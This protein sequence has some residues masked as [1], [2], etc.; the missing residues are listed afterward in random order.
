MSLYVYISEKEEFK[1]FQNPA[2]LFWLKENLIFGDWTSG[3][4][5]DGSYSHTKN[6][7]ITT[8]LR[9]NGSL[10]L[11]AYLTRLGD[12]PDPAS[13]FYAKQQMSYV[14]RQL[15]RFKHNKISTT[16]NLLTGES[17]VNVN[18]TGRTCSHWHPNMT[19]NLVVDHT[20]WQMGAVPAPMD[21]YVEFTAD[22]LHYK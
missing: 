17:G 1:D 14:K 3:L 7:P 13:Q 6:I 22:G 15:N 11:H 19:L 8:H 5:N 16:K 2:S 9:R 4:N 20:V 18:A 10:Y 12:H 21:E